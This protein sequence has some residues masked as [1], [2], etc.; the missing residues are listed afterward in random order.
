MFYIFDAIKQIKKTYMQ[1]V[2]YID[3]VFE[4]FNAEITNVD[5]SDIPAIPFVFKGY[6]R[7]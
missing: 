6:S 5:K 7:L 3:V 1:K 4:N 2:I